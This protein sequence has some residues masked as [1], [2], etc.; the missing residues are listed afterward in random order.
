[1]IDAM[2]LRHRPSSP[3]PRHRAARRRSAPD[4]P[5]QQDA[6]PLSRSARPLHARWLAGLLAVACALSGAPA[7]AAPGSLPALG[8]DADAALSPAGE[9][10]LGERIMRS[11][12]SDPDVIDDP[13]LR[14]HADLIWQRLLAAARQRGEI[15]ADLDPRFAWQAFLVRDRTV[16]AFALPGGY[17]GIHLGLIAVTTNRDQLASVLA[18]EL[19]HITQ[20]HIVRSIGIQQRQ[21]LVSLASMVLGVLAASRAPAA[22]QALMT[23]GQAVAM[24]DQL[25][26]SRDMEREADRVG[27]GVLTAAGFEADG[28]ATMFEKLAQASQLNDT[29]E[30]P[31]L[32]SHPLT[33]ERIG[34]AR[35]RL[36]PGMRP[37]ST[38]VDPQHQLMRERAR[39]LMDARA[40]ALRPLID[41]A[42]NP[43]PDTL[44]ALQ[45]VARGYGGTLAATLLRDDAAALQ[46]L[47]Q[48]RERLERLPAGTRQALQPE[49]DRLAAE[50]ALARGDGGAADAAL[51]SLAGDAT[52]PALLLRA[53]R[54]LLPRAEPAQLQAAAATLQVRVASA[55]DDAQAWALLGQCWDR[56][57]QPLRAARAHAE[58]SAALGR[59]PDAI[60]RLRS[61]RQQARSPSPTPAEFVELSV[62]DARLQ[63]LEGEMRQLQREDA[64]GS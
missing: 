57:G 61:A 21:S 58:S 29:L 41:E 51:A 33:T 35:A 1:M 46:A 37:L 5:A 8:E 24:Q 47:G 48:L 42:V 40:V 17:V 13:V 32:R 36:G 20:R 45:A 55:P 44:D 56:L 14:A 18:H 43:P 23:G 27:F 34:E 30:Y 3:M 49:I 39:V 11:I 12:R 52:R 19:T 2:T 38:R 15:T 62:I 22:A 63:A 60:E 31:Y 10:A 64:R 9:R 4:A 7:A 50:S 54:A 16:N 25:N 6:H 53:R 26:F 28:M 59:L